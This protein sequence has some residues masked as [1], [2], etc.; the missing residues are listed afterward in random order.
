MEQTVKNLPTM[1]RP[2]FSPWIQEI[3]WNRK[4]QLTPLFLP[5]KFHEQRSLLVYSPWG[6]KEL[7]TIE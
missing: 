7:D 4:W 3:P 6:F 1:R 5:G 2:R